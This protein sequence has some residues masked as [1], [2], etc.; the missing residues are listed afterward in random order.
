MYSRQIGDRVL[1]FGVSG[2][3]IRNGLVMYDR[4]TDTL[5]SQILSRAVERPL[6]GT[7]LEYL[8]SWQTT[9]A[10]WKARYPDSLFLIKGYAGLRDPYLGYYASDQAGVLGEMILGDR[11]ERKEFIIGVNLDGEAMA[12]PFSRLSAEPVVNTQLGGRPLLVLFDPQNASGVVFDRRG[13][14]GDAHFPAG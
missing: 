10:D 14:G 12:F 3:L 13:G 8:P 11:L 7:K 2:K 4:Q 9:Y 6:R 5:W 1:E